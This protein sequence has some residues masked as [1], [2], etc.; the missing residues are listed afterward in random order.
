MEIAIGLELQMEIMK[1]HLEI[2][3][4]YE[5]VIEPSHAPNESINILPVSSGTI[6]GMGEYDGQINGT[7]IAPAGEWAQI[8][9][10]GIM[11]PDVRLSYQIEND[12]VL[13]FQYTG[14]IIPNEK[15]A[16]RTE[17][18]ETIKGKDIY[19][20]TNPMIMTNSTTHSWIND[21]VFIGVMNELK[22]PTENEKGF[23]RYDIFRV[24]PH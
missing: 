11:K 7:L 24:V 13:Y 3:M 18:G 21:T 1:P 17:A 10:S 15:M 9:P 8:S 19:F 14:R 23:V 16:A 2:V 4:Q 6:T 22:M 12:E 5:A 20:V